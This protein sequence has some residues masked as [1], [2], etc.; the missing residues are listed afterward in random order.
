MQPYYDAWKTSSHNKIACVQCHYEPG[1]RSVLIQK[2]RATSQVVKYLTRTYSTRPRAEISDAA[3]LREGCHETRLLKGKV[4][5]KNILFDHTP[6][7][8]QMRRGETLRC[9]SCHSQIVQG[10]HITVTP[11]S[12]FI[13]HF[14]GMQKGKSFTSCLSCHKPPLKVVEYQGVKFDHQLALD[15]NISCAQCHLDVVQGNGAVPKERCFTCHNEPWKLEKY[16]DRP[17]LH[18]THVTEHKVDCLRCHD[19]IQHKVTQMADAIDINCS[20]CH[21]KHHAAQRELYMGIGGKGKHQNIIDPMFL[22]RVSCIGCHTL[23]HGDDVKGYTQI[24]SNSACTHC[25]T[26]QTGDMVLGWKQKT[27]QTITQLES[28]IDRAKKEVSNNRSAH[29]KQLVADAEYNIRLIKYGSAVHNIRYSIELLQ[30][31]YKNIQTALQIVKSNYSPPALQLKSATTKSDCEQC[32]L[33]IEQVTKPIFGVQFEH[34]QHLEIA[35]LDC[36]VCHLSDKGRSDSGRNIDKK[37]GLMIMTRVK[38][39]QCHHTQ[40]EYKCEGCHSLEKAWYNG[41]V[42]VADSVATPNPMAKSISCD[43]CHQDL[44]QGHKYEKVK[45]AC[46]S[47]HDKSYGEI[48][49]SWK[50]NIRDTLAEVEKLYQAVNKIT[51]EN[52][53]KQQLVSEARLIIDAVKAE[54]SH[55]IHNQDYADTLLTTAKKKLLQ[56]K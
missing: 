14:K 33:G 54:K 28:I 27:S 24:A 42:K 9:V 35:K 36:K 53:E 50:S 45:S 6:H 23:P 16:A 37:H 56:A 30:T 26:A 3:C 31:A 49:D 46:I 55:G 4:R 41:T 25:H 29:A 17:L 47:C 21:P 7:L 40:Q 13:C 38:C 52:K 51:N 44:N 43:A 15:R 11:T 22:A 5:F 10:Q 39:L 2:Y 1:I 12:C 19:V 48:A 18:K 20:E 34:Q 8:T 32:H